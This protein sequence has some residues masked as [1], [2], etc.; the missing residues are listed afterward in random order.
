[1]GP[2]QL[3]RPTNG[4][5][6]AQTHGS[7]RQHATTAL[8]LKPWLAAAEA[9]A[10]HRARAQP[11]E[12][13]RG[14]ARRCT[15]AMRAGP[16]RGGSA[17]DGQAGRALPLRLQQQPQLGGHSSVQKQRRPQLGASPTWLAFW[18]ACGA[19]SCE[20]ASSEHAP[21][22]QPCTR[23]AGTADGCDSC[24]QRIVAVACG[25]AWPTSGALRAPLRCGPGEVAG[26]GGLGAVAK[27]GCPVPSREAACSC[28]QLLA[29][30]V[31]V[32]PGWQSALNRK[33]PCAA[34]A[35]P[36]LPLARTPR[37]ALSWRAPHEG[38]HLRDALGLRLAGLPASKH[39][40]RL[41]RRRPLLP[42]LRLLRPSDGIHGAQTRWPC[43]QHAA[44]VAS[45]SPRLCP[46][47][48]RCAPAKPAPGAVH[49]RSPSR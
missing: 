8:P 34:P 44:G 5:H 45:G 48:P 21:S 46:D 41:P 13:G 38:T 47:Q 27:V 31:E 39:V 20:A 25:V 37:Q 30:S 32:P 36:L 23:M 28:L 42:L 10:R 35:R 6:G 22:R 11:R 26:S 3:L 29:G 12:L 17:L 49:G 16:R 14:A 33:H 4:I 15:L 2:L 18:L 24:R 9:G 7:T 40:W 19:D 1:M 43:R